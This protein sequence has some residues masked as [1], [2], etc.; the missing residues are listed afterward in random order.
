MGHFGPASSDTAL[1]T[2]VAISNSRHAGS[3]GSS[4]PIRPFSVISP[5]FIARLIKGCRGG[6][7]CGFLRLFAKT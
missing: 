3:G 4:L 6:V 7:S 1:T 2:M 5:A